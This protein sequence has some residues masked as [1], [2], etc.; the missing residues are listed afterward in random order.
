M[1]NELKSKRPIR[2]YDAKR[3]ALGRFFCRLLGDERGQG[4]L[5]EYVILGVLVI[6]AVVG[7]AILFS[8][9]VRDESPIM[10]YTIQGDLDKANEIRN[11]R[12]EQTPGGISE[13]K[14]FS[15]NLNDGQL[16]KTSSGTN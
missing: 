6:A 5:M 8:D 14:D 3:T 1:K 9:T 11:R 2:N 12:R 7:A 15:N 4:R 10:V 13:A 16:D